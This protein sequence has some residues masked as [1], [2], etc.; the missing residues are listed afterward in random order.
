MKEADPVAPGL[1]ASLIEQLIGQ[2]VEQGNTAAL[3]R[4][5]M[6]ITEFSDGTKPAAWQLATVAGALD[7]IDRRGKSIADLEQGSE[8]EVRSALAQLA[9]LGQ[10]ARTL[11]ADPDAAVQ[12]RSAAVRLLGRDRGREHEDIDTLLS[13]LSPQIPSEL[14]EE[15]VAAATRLRDSTVPDRLLDRWASH[16][17]RVRSAVLDS[18]LARESSWNVLLDRLEDGRVPA[19]HIDASYRQR[20]MDHKSAAVRERAARVFGRPSDETRAEILDEYRAAAQRAPD[21]QRGSAVFQK[22]CAGCHRVRNM[23]HE[24][25]PDLSAMAHRSPEFFLTAILDPN[26]AVEARYLSYLATTRDGRVLT[27]MLA[28]ETGNSVTLLAQDA[29][30]ETILRADIESLQS[31]GKSLMPE[32]IER[33]ISPQAM[34][35]LL[36]FL[37]SAGPPRKSFAG[38]N[39]EL[40]KPELLRHELYLLATTCEIYGSTLIF[41]DQYKNLG[42]W[43]SE[44]DHAVWNF[45]IDRAG[46]YSVSLDYA[47]DDTV[48]GNAFILEIGDVQLTGTVRGTGTWDTYK[49]LAVGTVTLPIGRHRLVFRPAGPITGALI[50]LRG[51]RITPSR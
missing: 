46:K 26:R 22:S 40:V 27:G 19:A 50:D 44:S 33:D 6:A 12:A 2:V 7:A 24:I 5:L 17:P 30:R 1:Q 21:A 18:L 3:A 37:H 39:P 41:E 20:L 4:S 35:D 29:K 47:C 13:L 25:G 16:G 49:P 28:A 10:A 31:S 36:A 23:G 14:Q 48:A 38:N 32:G 11:A 34:A 9:A 45:E 8:S 51:V 42:Y 43:S 15:A